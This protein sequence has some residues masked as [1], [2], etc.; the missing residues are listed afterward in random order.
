LS[1]LPE[2]IALDLDG[3]AVVYEPELAVAPVLVRLLKEV[4][5]YGM[6]WVMNSDRPCD[7]M[8]SLAMALEESVRPLAILSAQRHIFYKNEHGSYDPN[9]VFNNEMDRQQQALWDKIAQHFAKWTEDVERDFS[10]MQKFVDDTY[11]AFCV[12]VEQSDALR[13]KMQ[14]WMDEYDAVVSGNHEW[15]FVVP[16]TFSKGRLLAEAARH[17][18][19]DPLKILAVGDGLNDV[20]MLDGSVTPLVGAPGDCC[21]EV[22]EAVTRAGGIISPIT[23]YEGTCDIIRTVFELSR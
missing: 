23:N 10:V 13:T 19:V 18:N 14:G 11:F 9:I 4:Q 17:L 15:C 7:V 3:T 20:S 22:R 2:L 12:P 21:R 5:Q 1:V 16:S 8:I 6:Q